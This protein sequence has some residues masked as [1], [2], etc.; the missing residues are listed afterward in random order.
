MLD[1]EETGMNI[2][3]FFKTGAIWLIIAVLAVGNGLFRESVLVPG[4]GH[5]LALPLSGI[6][7]SAIV[8]VVTYFSFS[9]FGRQNAL[10]YVLIGAQWV[11]MTLLFEFGSG[12]YL[13]DR[14]LSEIVQVFD[15]MQGDFFLVVLAVSLFS[16]LLVA[17][18]K[19][20]L[21][22]EGSE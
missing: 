9:F 4:I 1:S 3:L 16:P 22:P 20:A 5:S 12:H 13:L 14:S 11:V 15:V 2:S 18:I 8:F 6:I 19:G 10:G 7:L 17:K 21:D